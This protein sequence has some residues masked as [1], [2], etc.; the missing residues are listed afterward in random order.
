[1]NY[2][3]HIIKPSLFR[4]A[5][6]AFKIFIVFFS[7]SSLLMLCLTTPSCPTLCDPID[8]TVPPGSTVHGILQAILDWASMLSSKGSFQPR[9]WTQVSCIAGGFF[10]VWATKEVQIGWACH[11]FKFPIISW[12]TEV[13][14]SSVLLHKYFSVLK[15]IFPFYLETS[16]L[17]FRKKI[18]SL[19]NSFTYWV[20]TV[21]QV[22]NYYIWTNISYLGSMQNESISLLLKKLIWMLREQQQNIKARMRPF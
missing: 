4:M 13:L 14:F 12:I 20:V 16:N 22:L 3:S 15:N 2:L 1:M 21:H 11:E 7:T 19:M 10:T 9:D 17:C 5:C 8:S 6:K 18:Y